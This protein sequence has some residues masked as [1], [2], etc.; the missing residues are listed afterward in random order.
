MARTF[1]PALARPKLAYNF[2]EN[3]KKI[4]KHE[5]CHNY[6]YRRK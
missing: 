3:A 5:R 4:Q 6:A 1:D 2:M